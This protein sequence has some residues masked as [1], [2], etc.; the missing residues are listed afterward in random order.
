MNFKEELVSVFDKY[1][2]SLTNKQIEQ[3]ETYYNLILEWN[4]KINLTSITEQRDVIIKHFLDSVLI[5]DNFKDNSTLIDVGAGAGFPS[6]PLKI[7]RPDLQV[8][9]VD[10]LNKRILFLNEVINKL[11]LSG[12]TAIHE[13]CEILAHKSEFRECF[14][15]CVARAVAELNV[16]TEY[17]LPFVKLFGYFIA[18]KSKNV[19]EE[20]VN[21]K[22]AV[23]L[24]GG[25][26]TD[27]KSFNID[28]INAER[29]FVF[30]QKK[31][32]TPVKYPRGQNK[33]RINPIK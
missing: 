8:T 22:K 28:E 31:F 6:I 30:T 27:I 3:F 5:C 9:M 14:D 13:R 17:C 16:L 12:I 18:Y 10:G 7:V 2:I 29:N 20:I 4:E 15:Y 21:S 33:P 24:L 1:D 25:K 26:I 11:N 23:E 19:N 32:K